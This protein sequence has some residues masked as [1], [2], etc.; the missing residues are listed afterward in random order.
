MIHIK[1]KSSDYIYYDQTTD[2]ILLVEQT[3]HLKN[4]IMDYILKYIKKY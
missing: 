2:G 1:N 4:H 3:I